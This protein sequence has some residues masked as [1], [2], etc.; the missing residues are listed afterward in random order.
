MNYNI[1]NVLKLYLEQIKAEKAI[2]YKIN[3]IANLI[4]IIKNYPKEIKNGEELKDIKGVGKGSIEK[5]NEIL[6]TGTLSYLHL[7]MDYQNNNNEIVNELTEVV[8]IGPVIA[9]KLIQKYKIKSLKEL[10]K[11]VNSGEIKVNDKIKLGLKYVGKFK[12]NIPRQ[13]IDDMQDYL[14][15]FNPHIVICGS[16]RR[17]LEYSSDIDVLLYSRDLLTM[18][19]VKKSNMLND[20]VNLL[21]QKKFVVDNITN[22]NVTKYMGFVKWENTIRRI[23]V[24]L[25]PYESIYTALVYFTGSYELNRIM[26]RQAKVLGYKLNEYG[27]YKNNKIIHITS[28]KELFKKLDMKYLKPTERNIN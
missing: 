25:I 9:N 17:G 11:K 12:G 14:K 21:T 22:N 1:I 24:R 7:Y 4:K 2:I 16:Y 27:L 5:I 6:K 23:D 26:R 10:I 13:H 3:A 18:D 8:G 20:Y 19:D 28:E 15:Q